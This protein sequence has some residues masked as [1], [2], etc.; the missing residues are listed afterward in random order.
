MLF[1]L[2]SSSFAISLSC[3]VIM[4][5]QDL[6]NLLM[7]YFLPLLHSKSNEKRTKMETQRFY[8]HSVNIQC[9]P[10]LSEYFSSSLLWAE[11]L[12]SI[13]L[14]AVETVTEHKKKSENRQRSRKVY[15]NIVIFKDDKQ[16]ELKR[17]ILFMSWNEQ[18]VQSDRNELWLRLNQNG[19]LNLW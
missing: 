15:Q 16:N 8:Y 9:Y 1:N 11:I 2:A 17:R 14:F 4:F 12:Y 13:L 7:E 19:S 3:I 18:S 6:F 10:N 5:Y